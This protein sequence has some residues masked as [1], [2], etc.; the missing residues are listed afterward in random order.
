[1]R[2]DIK[3]KRVHPIFQDGKWTEG[4]ELPSRAE[5]APTEVLAESGIPGELAHSSFRILG[6][7]DHFQAETGDLFSRLWDLERCGGASRI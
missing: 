1:M 2:E 4:W 7:S 6:A 3:D 5:Q